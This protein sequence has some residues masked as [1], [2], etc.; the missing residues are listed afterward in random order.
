M[1]LCLEML[2]S[3]VSSHPM[4]GH[5]G[6]QGDHT[7]YCIDIIKRVGSPNLKL[8]FD[9]YHVQIMDG[10]VISRHSP[11]PGLHRPRPHRRQPRPRRARRQAG[12]QL[13]AD[14]GSAARDRLPGPRRPGV[15]PDPRPARRAA[16]GRRALRR[17]ISGVA[18][19]RKINRYH[20][21]SYSPSR[22][23]R[24]DQLRR[25]F[26]DLADGLGDLVH[27]GPRAEERGLVRTRPPSS[28]SRSLAGQWSRSR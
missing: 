13:P 11:A 1:T 24:L 26:L 22:P 15:H 28:Q 27:I 18:S 23:L 19:G 6:Y 3:R 25:L 12:D 21:P 14:H 7:D 20:L 2:N 17:L 8:L 16:A 10:D 5:P 9:I 4:K